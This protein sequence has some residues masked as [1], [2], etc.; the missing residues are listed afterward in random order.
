[1]KL[2]IS[3]LIAV[4]ATLKLTAAD[5]VLVT[6][7]INITDG[8]WDSIGAWNRPDQLLAR[9][10]DANEGCRYSPYL[11]YDD[12]TELCFDWGNYRG[13]WTINGQRRCFMAEGVNIVTP[14]VEF[15][16]WSERNCT[17]N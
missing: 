16:T 4:T 11:A 14:D 6:S 2:A 10:L 15:T 12:W 5:S 13:H 1:M 8:T 17:W 9:A 3:T 7:F